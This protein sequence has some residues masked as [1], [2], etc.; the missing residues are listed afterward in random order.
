MHDERTITHSIAIAQSF[1]NHH[2]H[3]DV[4]KDDD[5]SVCKIINHAILGISIQFLFFCNI[6]KSYEFCSLPRLAYK[7]REKRDRN[8][9][10]SCWVSKKPI[11][12]P[13][14]YLF[15]WISGYKTKWNLKS[16]L[17]SCV[18]W[19]CISVKLCI[20]QTFNIYLLVLF[21]VFRTKND[22]QE[23]RKR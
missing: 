5:G 1:N 13:K 4:F 11:L 23:M 17:S 10:S 9:C 12:N 8:Q 15:T 18:V 22:R 14:S 19:A 2:N 3:K 21:F 6:L 16:H 20:G 7:K